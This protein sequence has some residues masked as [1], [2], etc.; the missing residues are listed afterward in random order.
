MKDGGDGGGGGGGG[1]D[2]G[3]A[4]AGVGDG[5]RRWG[6]WNGLGCGEL[7]RDLRV[8]ATS[9]L[10]FDLVGELKGMAEVSALLFGFK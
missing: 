5:G 10:H 7:C 8:K 3:E 1:G 9:G 2:G 6:E 4:A